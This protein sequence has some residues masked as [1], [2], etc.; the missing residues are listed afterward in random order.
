MNNEEKA[1]IILE[2]LEEYIQVNWAFEEYYTKAIKKGLKAIEEKEKRETLDRLS[3]P[4]TN[5]GK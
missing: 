5:Y 2:H 3:E 4:H 1:Y